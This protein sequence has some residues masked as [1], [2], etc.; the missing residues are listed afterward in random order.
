M[1]AVD[2]VMVMFMKQRSRRDPSAT[3]SESGKV[4]MGA[5]ARAAGAEAPPE[6]S[7]ERGRARLGLEG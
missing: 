3:T 7:G 5:A 6:A 2:S 1:V 4:M